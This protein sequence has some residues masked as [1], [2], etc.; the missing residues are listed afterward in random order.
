MRWCLKSP[1]TGAP[2][3]CNELVVPATC[4]ATDWHAPICDAHVPA[5]PSNPNPR[6]LA[7]CSHSVGFSHAAPPAATACL[8]AM[9]LSRTVSLLHLANIARR[10]KIRVTGV[11]VGEKKVWIAGQSEAGESKRPWCRAGRLAAGAPARSGPPKNDMR[12]SHRHF[13]TV[14]PDS[15]CFPPWQAVTVCLEAAG[16]LARAGTQDAK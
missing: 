10:F 4:V 12:G 6:L 13:C 9:L 8:F 14:F 7:A 2:P 1:T 16:G 3:D 11:T 5:A 15:S